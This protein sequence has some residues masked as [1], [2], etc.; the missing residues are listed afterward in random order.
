[1]VNLQLLLSFDL[2]Q[3]YNLYGE[4]TDQGPTGYRTLNENLSLISTI[5]VKLPPMNELTT[6]QQSWLNADLSRSGGSNETEMANKRQL[7]KEDDNHYRLCSIYIQYDAENENYFVSEK[8]PMWS[9][10]LN[11]ESKN[12]R[13]TLSDL[14]K[15]WK[16]VKK[17]FEKLRS[18]VLKIFQS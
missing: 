15:T 6:M 5:R 18:K 3:K 4:F 9:I 8:F 16:R 7:E 11:N 13:F 14:K 1:M 2:D 12:M 17:I 10:F